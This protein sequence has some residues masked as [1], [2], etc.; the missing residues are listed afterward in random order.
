MRRTSLQRVEKVSQSS[1][2]AGGESSE[3]IFCRSMYVAENTSRGA[4][5]E[6]SAK[7]GQ[8][9]RRAQRYL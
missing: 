9:R 8:S 1:P 7:G 2:P 6:L 5:V 3:M 4:S